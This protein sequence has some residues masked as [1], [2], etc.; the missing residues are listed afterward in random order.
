LHSPTTRNCVVHSYHPTS[1]QIHI[2]HPASAIMGRSL[3]SFWLLSIL[4]LVQQAVAQAATSTDS[5]AAP[6]KSA[7]TG[8]NGGDDNPQD[9][10]DAGAAGASKGAFN[11]S[12]GGLA[13]IVVVAVLVGVVGSKHQ[14]N[15]A[16]CFGMPANSIFSWLRSPFLAREEA[17]MGRPSIYPKGFAPSHGTLDCGCLL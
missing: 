1:I 16:G 14:S 6:Q 17:S 10:S 11:L 12:K 9:P 8:Y 2:L 15:G 7:N 5:S 4:V 13:A 3:S